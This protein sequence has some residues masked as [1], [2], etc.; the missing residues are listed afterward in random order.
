MQAC[1]A[2]L[3]DQFFV[4]GGMEPPDV[5]TDEDEDDFWSAENMCL[6]S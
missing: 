3:G 6:W 5:D 1:S 4:F 2:T